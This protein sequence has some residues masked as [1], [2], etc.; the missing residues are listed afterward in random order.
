M[1]PDE[2]GIKPHENRAIFFQIFSEPA[3]SAS[4]VLQDAGLLEL[5]EA[6]RKGSNVRLARPEEQRG[7]S[8]FK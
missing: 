2:Q 6:G 3:M 4:A 8:A 5:A 1:P 7:L